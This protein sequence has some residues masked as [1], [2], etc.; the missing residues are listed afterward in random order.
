MHSLIKNRWLVGM[1]THTHKY[2]RLI[3]HRP[4]LEFI[5]VE[6]WILPF[7]FCSECFGTNVWYIDLAM[8]TMCVCGSYYV[9]YVDRVY[10]LLYTYTVHTYSTHIQYTLYTCRMYT[11]F[12]TIELCVCVEIYWLDWGHTRTKFY[13][14]L[15]MFNL[16]NE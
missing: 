6:L 14:I 9:H 11:L 8:F 10:T 3:N 5:I 1:Q 12:Q 7:N 13:S 15:K 16:W 2:R 4:K